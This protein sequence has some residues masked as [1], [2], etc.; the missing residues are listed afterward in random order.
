MDP[1]PT[2]PHQRH[3]TPPPNTPPTP[4]PPRTNDDRR[5]LAAA[6]EGRAGKR[7]RSNENRHSEKDGHSESILAILTKPTVLAQT[8]P[9]LAS[10]QFLRV[11]T[12]KHTSKRDLKQKSIQNWVKNQ[13][14]KANARFSTRFYQ[15]GIARF[16]RSPAPALWVVWRPPS[17][18]L[19]SSSNKKDRLQR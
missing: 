2:H 8:M 10:K 16:L 4:P 13:N 19:L 9:F 12:A 1:Q 14:H 11:V 17:S 18:S 15:S 6:T 7:S 5:S 3:D